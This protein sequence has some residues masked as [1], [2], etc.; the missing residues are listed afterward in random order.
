[1][2][3]TAAAAAAAPA[4]QIF[5]LIF[6]NQP[7]I[8]SLRSGH[9][10]KN[11]TKLPRYFLFFIS[12]YYYQHAICV[13]AAHCFYVRINIA[14]K[15]RLCSRVVFALVLLASARAKLSCIIFCIYTYMTQN[16][17]GRKKK[18]ISNN[19]IYLFYIVY[20]TATIHVC[21]CF[22]KRLCI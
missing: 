22:V 3:K 15:M 14:Q 4:P 13:R 12:Y 9:E 1:M 17:C 16:I 11:E 2:Y 21:V 18:M 8:W 7:R 5:N 6:C 19:A 20:T 10:K